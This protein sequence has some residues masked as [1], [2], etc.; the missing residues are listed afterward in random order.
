MPEKHI[1]NHVVGHTILRRGAKLHGGADD[2]YPSRS[3]RTGTRSSAAG[4]RKSHNA[5]QPGG[6]SAPQEEFVRVFAE[7]P[8]AQHRHPH[9]I[10]WMDR[11]REWRAY[12]IAYCVKPRVRARS[13]T[14]MHC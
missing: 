6:A 11:M 2:G 7:H 5:L 4:P 14:Q 3:R 12:I 9:A 8:L 13:I 10:R 1:V